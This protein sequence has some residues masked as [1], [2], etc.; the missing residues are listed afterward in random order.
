MDYDA[1]LVEVGIDSLVAV[2]ARS[3]FLKELKVDVPV[4]KL[5]GGASITEICQTALE[6]LPEGLLASIGKQDVEPRKPI[7]TP[8]PITIQTEHQASAS[9]TTTTSGSGYNSGSEA[10]DPSHPQSSVT[11]PPSPRSVS[12]EELPDE[13]VVKDSKVRDF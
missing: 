4:L 2:E 13:I 6:K 10:L 3:W 11:T 7:P 12:A 9:G 1:P 8:T 5:V